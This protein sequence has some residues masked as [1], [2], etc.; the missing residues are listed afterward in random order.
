MGRLAGVAGIIAA[1][2]PRVSVGA[3]REPP[4]CGAVPRVVRVVGRD[5]RF[6][7]RPLGV[8]DPFPG[9]L[10]GRIFRILNPA[11]GIAG[12][13]GPDAVQLLGA[14]DDVFEV[15]ALPERGADGFGQSVNGLAGQIGRASRRERV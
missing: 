14:A 15:V 13:V 7:N 1:R 2:G 9:R 11:G 10:P 5:E 4:S 12:D 6:A 8:L 3:V